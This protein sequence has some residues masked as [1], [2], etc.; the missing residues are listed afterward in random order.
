MRR[1]PSSTIA[2]VSASPPQIPDS[3]FSRIRFRPWHVLLL[4]FRRRG[5]LNAG[6]YTTPLDYGLHAGL[7]PNLMA[8]LPRPN[9]RDRPRPTRCPEP[10]CPLRVLPFKEWR[11]PPPREALPSHHRSYGLMRQ[12]KTLPLP[13]VSLYSKSL[14]VVASPCW[15]L[16]LPDVI[17]ASPSLGAWTLTPVGSYGAYARFF[18]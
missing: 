6:S 13:S 12:T 17:S 4:P 9:V 10:L 3:R 1:V 11:L 16:A 8:Q 7:D 14:Q 18:P 2:H 15:E 5:S